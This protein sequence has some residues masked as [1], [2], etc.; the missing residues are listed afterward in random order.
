MGAAT[1][2]RDQPNLRTRQL[3]EALNPVKML[4]CEGKTTEYGESVQMIPHPLSVMEHTDPWNFSPNCRT[5]IGHKSHVRPIPCTGQKLEPG[6]GQGP[7]LRSVFV[8]HLTQ[9]EPDPLLGPKKR[10][11]EPQAGY[12]S[13][14]TTSIFQG[15]RSTT[16]IRKAVEDCKSC[17]EMQ[18]KSYEEA[19]TQNNDDSHYFEKIW[20]VIKPK[21]S[22]LMYT[23]LLRELNRHHGL[24]Y[25]QYM[26]H[27]Q[28]YVSSA[29]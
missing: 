13:T 6:Y 28:L 12:N 5:G 27:T 3:Q 14:I 25:P 2:S 10:V 20:T 16:D 29:E 22:P 21:N 23:K 1:G 8:Q 4:S 26:D 9:W 15:N 17:Q 18:K 7:S 19:I 11:R 24:H